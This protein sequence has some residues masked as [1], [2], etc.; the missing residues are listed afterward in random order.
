MSMTE[1]DTPPPLP[2]LSD[3]WDVMLVW[4]KGNINKNCLC[5]TV[6]C[7]VIMVHKDNKQFLGLQV[8]RLYRALILPVLAVF[9]APLCLWTVLHG[10]M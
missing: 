1:C 4:R 2:P 9:Q 6:L 8:G 5:A 3:I 10:A 7:T